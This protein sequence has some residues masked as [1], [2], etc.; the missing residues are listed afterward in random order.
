MTKT[1]GRRMLRAA[2]QRGLLDNLRRRAARRRGDLLP[3]AAHAYRV[4]RAP[5]PI[6]TDGDTETFDLV[7]FSGYEVRE[8]APYLGESRLSL[9][10]TTWKR[11]T[12]GMVEVL[13]GEEV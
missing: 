4:D 12:R 11:I 8:R 6:A 2:R 5:P 3:S 10:E 13:V 7:A 1:P 9:G